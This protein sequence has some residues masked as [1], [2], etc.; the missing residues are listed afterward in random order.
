MIIHDLDVFS[1][2]VR[3]MEA[4]AELIVNTNAV[5]AYTVPFQGFQSITRWNSQIVELACDL[6]LS[7]LTSCHSR[8]IR[9]SPDIRS[10]GERLRISTLKRLDHGLQ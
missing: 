4:E 8:N 6:Q 1:T 5:L 7:Q 10:F 2:R 9:E 3:P